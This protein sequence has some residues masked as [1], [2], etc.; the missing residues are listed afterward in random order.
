MYSETDKLQ[1]EVEKLI[2]EVKI[3][4]K[5]YLQPT[6]WI[7]VIALGVSV[8]G[9]IGQSL[10]YESRATIAKADVA[11]AK[12][13]RIEMEKKRDEAQNEL[14]K[15]QSQLLSI[16]ETIGQ[17]KQESN[18]TQVQER[19]IEVEKKLTNLQDTTQT[20][21]QSLA[22]SESSAV[23]EFR[24][25]QQNTPK[26]APISRLLTAKEKEREGFQ[27]LLDGDYDNAIAAFQ[28]AENAYNSYHNVYEIARLLRQNKSQMNDPA[29]K[30]EIFQKI[31]KDYSYGAPPDLLQQVKAIANQ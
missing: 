9:N 25:T 14:D 7:G 15:L 23:R 11:Q 12:L 26:S 16:Q 27:N 13:D 22:T 31:V 20:T 29:K 5:P 1:N 4:K 18:S 24:E 28:A 3:L 10:T 17:A 30:K 6:F 19:L 2:A 21:Q 8:A